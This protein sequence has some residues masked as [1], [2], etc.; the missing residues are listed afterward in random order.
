MSIS[1]HQEWTGARGAKAG[2]PGELGFLLIVLAVFSLVW[3]VPG[4]ESLGL[5]FCSGF[6]FPQGMPLG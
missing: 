3:N 1:P 5:Q 4:P 6:T 2:F